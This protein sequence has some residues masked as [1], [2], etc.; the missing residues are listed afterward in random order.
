MRADR[1]RV[2]RVQ[3]LAPAHEQPVAARSAE[4]QVGADLRQQ[5]LADA[6]AIPVIASGGLASLDDVRQLLTPRA[7]KLEGAITG[8]ALYDGRLDPADAIA[9]IR[10][11]RAA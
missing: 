8:K 5:D 6:V 3:R 10:T 9:L 11:A 1:F 2:Y 7:A 4:A